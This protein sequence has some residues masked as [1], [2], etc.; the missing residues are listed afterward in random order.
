MDWLS[1]IL[2]LATLPALL[3]LYLT[4]KTLLTRIPG[5]AGAKLGNLSR[6]SSNPSPLQFN[7]RLVGQLSNPTE[8]DEPSVQAS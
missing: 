4:G 3:A 1:Y 2:G 7:R 8:T 5:R 6:R